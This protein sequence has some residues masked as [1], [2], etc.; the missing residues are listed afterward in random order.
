MT[1]ISLRIEDKLKSELQKRAKKYGISMNQLINITL[2]QS[3]FQDGIFLDF[4][5][6]KM[7]NLSRE[8]RQDYLEARD[9]IQKHG[10]ERLSSLSS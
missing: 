1:T 3:R 5:E 8:N 7:D 4:R 2:A 9:D 6:E 10:Y